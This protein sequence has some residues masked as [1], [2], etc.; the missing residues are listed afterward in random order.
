[1]VFFYWEMVVIKLKIC[2]IRDIEAAKAVADG[3]DYIGFIMDARFRRYISPE[4]V[5]E[6]C[7]SV[8]DLIKVGVFVDQPI[9][10]VNRLAKFCG[11]DMIQLHGHEPAEYAL[12]CNRP[13]IKAFRYGDDFLL[14]AAEAYPAELVLIDSYSRNTVGGSGVSFA[15]RTAAEEICKLKKRYII[16]GGIN[17]QNVREA[18]EL[19]HPYAIDA[20]GSM[21][22]EGN[23]S[24]KL[25]KEF[26]KAV[27]Q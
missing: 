26:I 27:K 6:I 14:E 4:Q 23:K 21:E 7:S 11:L 22:I 12:S 8:P 1:M 18:I 5:K 16:A 2:G 10:E 19:F 20:S 15:W 25:I 24:P 17:S 13:V 3:A 9:D